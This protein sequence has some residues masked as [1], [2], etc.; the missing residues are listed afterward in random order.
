MISSTILD[1]EDYLRRPTAPPP[2]PHSP[3][4]P[5][6]I[7]RNF[8]STS[9][10]TPFVPITHSQYA[11]NNQTNPTASHEEW[12]EYNN[13]VDLSVDRNLD[14]V[15]NLSSEDDDLD[16]T[17]PINLSRKRLMRDLSNVILLPI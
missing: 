10:T 2:L 4:V 16:T 5:P 12:Q 9:R 13:I 8:S 6:E 14:V 1:G 15:I 17:Q 11:T 3:L 7:Y